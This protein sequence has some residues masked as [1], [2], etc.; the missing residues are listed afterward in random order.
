MALKLNDLK[1]II[2]GI[3][4]GQAFLLLGQQ[5]LRVDM[6]YYT[7]LCKNLSCAQPNEP[8]SLNELWKQ[9]GA[10][11][12]KSAMSEAAD[13]AVCLL[14]FR[15]MMSLGWRGVFTSS[16]NITW[17]TRSTG[18]NFNLNLLDRETLDQSNAMNRNVFNKKNMPLIPLF[19]DETSLPDNAD[20]LRKRKH[21]KNVFKMPCEKILD[22]YGYLIVDG[23]EDDDWF[24]LKQLYDLISG[25]P[26][27]GLVYLFG[28]TRV[29]LESI[30]D[31]EETWHDFKDL[32][33]ENK[34]VL[35]EKSFRAVIEELK[36][37]ED[38]IDDDEDHS[39]EVSVRIGKNDIFWLKR[40]DCVRLQNIGITVLR[41]EL[42]GS[43]N[44]KTHDLREEFA[45]FLMDSTRSWNYFRT[46]G[47]A[48]NSF[49]ISR[50]SE[51]SLK[52]A[53]IDQLKK[54]ASQRSII[55]L[56]GNSN[57]G[58]STTLKWFARYAYEEFPL[59]GS[60][61]KGSVSN[62]YI[63][64]YIY[65]D[66]TIYSEHWMEEL[67][68][69]I[70]DSIYDG[71]TQK[72]QRIS[73][74]LIIWDNGNVQTK[75]KTYE[76]LSSKLNECN[77]VLVGS[78]YNFEARK[79]KQGS[80][81][82]E[83][84]IDAELTDIERREL[85][86]LLLNVDPEMLQTL[87]RYEK[88][89]REHSDRKY[90]FRILTHLAEYYHSPKW[91]KFRQL[92]NAKLNKEARETEKTTDEEFRLFMDTREAVLKR[93]IG[94]E[95]QL[96]IENLDPNRQ[97]LNEPLKNA[98]T[99]MN[100]ILAV[101]GQFANRI[102]LPES[103]LLKTLMKYAPFEHEVEKLRKTL[104]LDSMAKYE[105]NHETGRASI[106][107]R[108][109]S[110]ALE[111]LTLVL[112]SDDKSE[113]K[114]NRKT[115]EINI[116]KRL[117]Q[118]CDWETTT[119]MYEA[120]AVSALI[121]SFGANSYGKANDSDEFKGNYIVYSGY[122]D[123]IV[124]TMQGQCGNNPDAHL[125]IAHFTRESIQLRQKYNNEDDIKK[126][127]KVFRDMKNI[128]NEQDN[129]QTYFSRQTTSSRLYGE[130]CK[131][132]L[133]C[134]ELTD[135]WTN[136]EMTDEF[137][138]TFHSAVN[139]VKRCNE[140]VHRVGTI[141]LLDIWMKY[142]SH[143]MK[144]DFHQGFLQY[145]SE[146][147]EYIETL[148]YDEG[149]HIEESDDLTSVLKNINEFYSRIGKEGK[150]GTEQLKVL[151]RNTNNDSWI[152]VQGKAELVKTYVAFQEEVNSQ[153]RSD[154]EESISPRV[155]FL[156]EN[157][158]ED[159]NSS[160]EDRTLFKRIKQA[161]RGV[162]EK[163]ISDMDQ[164]YHQNYGEMSFRCLRMYCQAKW[165]CYTGNLLL[166]CN[167][168]PGLND[169]QWKEMNSICINALANSGNAKSE[170]RAL[171]FIR[172]IYEFVFEGKH[173][174]FKRERNIEQPDRRICLCAPGANGEEARARLFRV[175][176]KLNNN[177]IMAKIE[178]EVVDGK[179][180]ATRQIHS[181]YHSVYVPET[182]LKKHP[183]LKRK[184][185]TNI[186]Q[187]FEIWFNLSGPQLKDVDVSG[188]EE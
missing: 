158:A 36:L 180:V 136:R 119:G 168:R 35:E 132:L 144:N 125:T 50:A 6:N 2:N 165:L 55:L 163:I 32:L 51:G 12:L 148:L 114:T 177:K 87:R 22:Q 11:K 71:V 103:L 154:Q 7:Q 77:I 65:D 46:K 167:Q 146:T 115:E 123:E 92:L 112:G 101:V 20:V 41:D 161:L 33:N 122:W 24:N 172:S 118:N 138:S 109:S 14:W 150:K 67:E 62:R 187:D 159:F 169:A 117:I 110:E 28:M 88:D 97:K 89:Y 135:G 5:Y 47:G 102:V 64:L 153:F 44:M 129:V 78:I 4:T 155:F 98:I 58:K 128:V 83:V 15:T 23:I 149:E 166:E 81:P 113:E 140:N 133:V 57:T 131:N 1:D 121:R 43:L 18:D 175:S 80:R 160:E 147:L 186:G 170:T 19:G 142:V 116:L 183:N 52:A 182:V 90:L 171:E 91:Q 162:A 120:K 61:G 130:M 100:L 152:Y 42:M 151:F 126:L 66:P 25:A 137:I 174:K 93:G 38:Y 63:V 82:R 173:W 104:A 105:F 94:S 156:N 85:E 68:E 54:A 178:K 21:V 107:F 10:D 30:C 39:E 27:P 45:D 48:I 59:S 84:S 95:I 60:L 157:A 40:S 124:E 26:S 127:K 99:D 108:H 76:K 69:F 3:Q 75:D 49:H 106:S 164:L 181:K 139:E 96:A 134:I 74:V 143:W 56:K 145:I 8:M 111:Y 176:T 31:N 29:R 9:N 53:V 37:E 179:P 79:F 73:N 72:K 34:L 185:L 86:K 13:N 141:Q 16:P 17:F 70:K 184:A 188:E